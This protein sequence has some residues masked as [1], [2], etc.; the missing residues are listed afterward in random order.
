MRE[1]KNKAVILSGIIAERSEAM[2]ESKDPA[3]AG[4]DGGDDRHSHRDA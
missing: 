4:S 3:K 1:W 2:M